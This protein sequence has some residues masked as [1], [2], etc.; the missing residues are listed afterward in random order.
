MTH[1][2]WNLS[3]V[4]DIVADGDWLGVEE[5]EDAFVEAFVAPAEQE[6]SG[7]EGEFAGEVLVELSALRREDQEAPGRRGGG[8][9]G[10]DGFDDRRG[11]E[12]HAGTAAEGAIVDLLVLALGPVAEVPAMDGEQVAF[13][14]AFDQ[15][16]GQER[17]EQAGEQGQE[18]DAERTE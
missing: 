17:V 3:A 11:H 1:H 6:Q 10:F 14:R 5:V 18:I 9:D 2:G 12:D 7:F 16:L 15:A 8:G 4:Q 13:D